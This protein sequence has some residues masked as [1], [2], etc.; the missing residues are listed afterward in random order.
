M[1]DNLNDVSSTFMPPT[2]GAPVRASRLRVDAPVA[3]R[4]VSDGRWALGAT[5]DISATGI[6]FVPADG[7]LP[8]SPELQV[9][10][11]LSRTALE[12][13]GTPLPMPDLYC[14]GSVAR[15]TQDSDGRWA[16]AVRIDYEWANPPADRLW[17]TG[18]LE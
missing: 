11:Y 14:G 4:S 2:A 6:L 13:N 10:V 5:I 8:E 16:L 18:L 15:V 12:V 9:V 3:Y 7:S 1:A 17:E